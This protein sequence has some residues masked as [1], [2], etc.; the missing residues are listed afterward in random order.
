MIIFALVLF[1]V[2]RIK[3]LT[4]GHSSPGGLIMGRI[5]ESGLTLVLDETR[6]NFIIYIDQYYENQTWSR[7]NPGIKLVRY[8]EYGL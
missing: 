8:R 2:L 3:L 6:T 4:N 5:L 1:N 7:F